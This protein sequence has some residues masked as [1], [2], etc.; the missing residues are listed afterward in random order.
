MI[1]TALTWLGNGL[2][3]VDWFF[4]QRLPGIPLDACTSI[5]KKLPHGGKASKE[6]VEWA[7]GQTANQGRKDLKK[8]TK[9]QWKMPLCGGI[10]YV[11]TAYI[12]AM[13]E[14]HGIFLEQNRKENPIDDFTKKVI[15]TVQVK[16]ENEDAIKLDTIEIAVKKLIDKKLPSREKGPLITAEMCGYGIRKIANTIAAWP[17]RFGIFYYLC[18][19]ESGMMSAAFSAT[20]VYLWTNTVLVHRVRKDLA[21]TSKGIIKEVKFTEQEQTDLV[22]QV[23]A[24]FEIFDD[25]NEKLVAFEEALSA[26]KLKNTIKTPFQHVGFA[27][28]KKSKSSSEKAETDENTQ[29]SWVAKMEEAKKERKNHTKG[30]R[31]YLEADIKVHEYAIKYYEQSKD[32]TIEIRKAIIKEDCRRILSKAALFRIIKRNK[33]ANKYLNQ[34]IVQ[35]EQ[36]MAAETDAKIREFLIKKT[37]ELREALTQKVEAQTKFSNLLQTSE[38]EDSDEEIK[39]NP[40]EVQKPKKRRKKDSQEIKEQAAA[41]E[42]K[43]VEKKKA[44]YLTLTTTKKDSDSDTSN[45]GSE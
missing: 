40:L 34:K 2:G 37:N 16:M 43:K 42:K 28:V 29:D 33:E 11:H 26:L 8:A 10:E 4:T 18:P 19:S 30:S 38:S 14:L 21:E 39:T 45:E 6:I 13:R 41:T 44:T 32:P 7:L 24:A 3:K 12:L 23:K 5:A 25:E 20:C 27:D 35:F 1:N 36:K 9:L 31:E 15:N 17:V 22:K